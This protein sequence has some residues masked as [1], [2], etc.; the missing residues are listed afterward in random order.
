MGCPG[1]RREL[2]QDRTRELLER[3]ALFSFSLYMRAEFVE[4]RQA[5]LS[6]L[7]D[8]SIERRSCGM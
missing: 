7:I 1:P 4:R 5:V 6:R 2:V 8:T 3:A